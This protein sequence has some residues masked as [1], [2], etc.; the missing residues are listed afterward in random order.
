MLNIDGRLSPSVDLTTKR[1]EAV[2]REPTKLIHQVALLHNSDLV[3]STPSVRLPC[4][5]AFIH[6]IQHLLT[7]V[8]DM[9]YIDN[10]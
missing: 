9:P 7:H 2:D 4:Y 8:I 10:S 3:P 5:A 1:H 6:Y